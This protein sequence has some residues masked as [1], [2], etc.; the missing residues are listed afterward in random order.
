[1]ILFTGDGGSGT[2]YPAHKVSPLC[3]K[4]TLYGYFY[5]EDGRKVFGNP[6]SPND[7]NC[8]NP[9]DVEY[10]VMLKYIGMD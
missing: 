3:V 2:W 6:K 9:S 4:G 7:Q 10:D 5:Q 8:V 1:M